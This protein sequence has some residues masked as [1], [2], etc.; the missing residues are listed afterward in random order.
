VLNYFS[1]TF[2]LVVEN[3]RSR[4]YCGNENVEIEKTTSEWKRVRLYI[5]HPLGA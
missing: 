1:V 2:I 3:Y 5:P 4:N